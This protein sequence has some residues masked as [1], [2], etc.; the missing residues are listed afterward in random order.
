MNR[1]FSPQTNLDN[2]KKEAK[3]WLKALRAGNPEARARLMRA[4]PQAP[5]ASAL[6][7]VQRALALE[8][9]LDGWPALKEALAAQA[10]ERQAEDFV[11]AYNTG[12]AAALERLNRHYGLSSTWDDL[13]SQVWRGVY[14]V[15]QG[16]PF[17]IAEA[18]TLV[19][20]HAGFNNW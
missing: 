14:A 8:H 5:A 15:R 10:A 12:D 11:L 9:G 18:R 16:K 17:D 6:R 3:R 1:R 4:Y 19:A 20:R 13:R 2:L 7:D